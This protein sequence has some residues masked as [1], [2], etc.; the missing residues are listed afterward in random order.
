M[1]AET[2]N[3]F[4][5]DASM[6]RLKAPLF[7]LLSSLSPLMAQ[8]LD[9]RRWSHLPI[10]TNFFGSAYA[11]TEGDISF[12]P[13]LLITGTEVR[14][15][16][17]ALAYI[18]TF[19]LLGKTARLDVVQGWRDARWTGKLDGV[20]TAV[21]RKGLADTRLRV[22]M[23]LIGAPPLSGKEYA[24]YRAATK[25]ETILGVALNVDLPTGHYKK[26]KLLNIGSNRFTF[27]PQLG[28]V[29][30]R[31]NWTIEGTAAVDFYTDNN[32]FFNGNKLEQDPFFN[33]QVHAIRDFSPGFWASAS[34]G[35]GNGSQSTVNG[36]E[37]DDRKEFVAWALSVGYPVTKRLSIKAA[38]ISTRRQRESGLESDTLTVGFSTFW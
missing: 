14:V 11:H 18:R 21:N 23:N 38:Y 6:F 19:Q 12:D 2:P 7:L 16:T 10:N 28:A 25:T 26:D 15:Q 5:P 29:H 35:Y 20:D 3:I 32:S 36:E 17:A 27:S 4:G 24:A 8:E 22:S 33:V 30:T 1:S 13:V 31:G 9:P 37:K 34:L